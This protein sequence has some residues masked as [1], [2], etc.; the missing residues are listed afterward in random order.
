MTKLEYNIINNSELENKDRNAFG[1][2]L[3]EQNKVQGDCCTK[4]DRCK[5]I[6]IVK[7]NNSAIAIGGIK[8]KTISDF[9]AE[10]A[11]L[12]NWSLNF[13]WE[14]GYLYSSPKHSGKGIASNIVNLLLNEFGEENLM[15]STEIYK[16]PAM[17]KI[18]SKHGFK[19]YGKPWKSSIHDNYL[20]LFLKFK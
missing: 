12:E 15:A 13:E 6:C 2:L 3:I 11:D 10:K 16:N 4:A 17:V 8:P 9:S 20:G 7:E 18:L 19:Q 14:L 5:M 1:D